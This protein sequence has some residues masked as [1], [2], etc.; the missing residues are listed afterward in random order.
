MG[1]TCKG[2]EGCTRD[3]WILTFSR[4]ATIFQIIFVI[5]FV[6]LRSKVGLG[7]LV[8]Y[9]RKKVFDVKLKELKT[10]L[11]D[12]IAEDVAMNEVIDSMKLRCKDSSLPDVD[13]VRMVWA[14]LMDAIQWSGKNQ[15]QNINLALRQVCGIFNVGS[16]F[17][18]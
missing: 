18:F 6:F 2:K 5:N 14:A 4:S 15:Q 11:T 12:Q 3:F 7:Q 8:E 17:T 9:N 1:I 10:S 13:V 16:F